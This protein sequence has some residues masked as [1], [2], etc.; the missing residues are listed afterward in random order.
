[1]ESKNKITHIIT[2]LND[3]GAEAVLYRLC[4]NDTRNKHI[5]ISMMDE[6]K[7]GPLLREIGVDVYTLNMRAG[8]VSFSGLIKLYRLIKEIDP[9]VVQTWMYHADLIG[10][11]IARLAGVKKIFWNIRHTTLEKGISKKSTFMIA[12]LSAKLSRVIP[13]KIVCCA[14]KA[15]E[16]H[17][18]L[19]YQQDKLIVIGNGYELEKFSPDLTSA[20]VFR[21]ELGCGNKIVLGMV[22][23]YDP[24]KDHSNLLKALSLV[25]Q[26]TSNFVCVLVGRDLASDN[27]NL[28]N[29]I[30]RL[31]LSEDILLLGQRNDIPKVMNGLDLHILSSMSEGFPNVLAEAMA[32]G[33]PCI[34]TNVGD[35]AVIVGD[36]GWVVQS[37]DSELL[38]KGIFAA[39]EA[40]KDVQ[41]WNSRKEACRERI[42]S[43]F[44]IEQMVQS[45]DAL[46]SASFKD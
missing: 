25:K 24:L 8:R 26:Q 22:G 41:S 33:T 13:Y 5:V 10:G 14:T 17:A 28:M 6:G 30:D 35:A 20:E 3:G 7:Y 4:K 23:R 31:E 44:G 42:V 38:A 46:W 16:V 37:R 36:T 12:K 32:C 19:G 9:D 39:L 34:T 15:L 29:E 27:I 11:V 21:Y 2:G 1:M 43:Y 18:N 45:Y 40:Q